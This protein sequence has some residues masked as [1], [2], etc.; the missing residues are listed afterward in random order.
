VNS[1]H[2]YLCAA[3]LAALWVRTPVASLYSGYRFPPEIISYG[4]WAHHRFCLS[5]RDVKD[6]LA[7]GGVRSSVL[8]MRD[9]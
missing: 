6:L 1:S 5:C 7:G 2:R 8:V 9:N 3:K 4:V